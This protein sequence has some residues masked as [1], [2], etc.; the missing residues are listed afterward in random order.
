MKEMPWLSR[1]PALQAYVRK[2]TAK[3]RGQRKPRLRTLIADAE[4]AGKNVASITT[5]DGTTLTFGPEPTAE[6]ANPW[7]ADIERTMQ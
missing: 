6:A 7:L 5:P 4:K 3:R 2:I 1:D